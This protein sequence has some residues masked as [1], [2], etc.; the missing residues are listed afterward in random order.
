MRSLADQLEKEIEAVENDGSLSE[1]EK[2]EAIRG[3]EREY[4]DY[5]REDAQAAYD[6]AME[7][8]GY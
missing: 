8:N 3:L 7:R 6:Q 2:Q 5:A 1:Q 4:R